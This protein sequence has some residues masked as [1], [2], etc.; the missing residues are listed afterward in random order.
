MTLDRLAPPQKNITRRTA[1]GLAAA[2]LLL[3]RVVPLSCI[4]YKDHNP[5]T[6]IIRPSPRIGIMFDNDMPIYGNLVTHVISCSH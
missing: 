2:M 6:A 1:I 5:Q 4:S 3:T